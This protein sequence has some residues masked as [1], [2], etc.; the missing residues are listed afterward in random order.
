MCD[1]SVW[2]PLNYYQLKVIFMAISTL[3][4]QSFNFST[5]YEALIIIMI[6]SN[7]L[8]LTPSFRLQCFYLISLL[9]GPELILNTIYL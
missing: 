4:F 6:R 2:V 3:V 8:L 7:A 5:R 9:A 1:R